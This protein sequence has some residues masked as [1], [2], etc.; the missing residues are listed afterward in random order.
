[1]KA[2]TELEWTL[3]FRLKKLE[4]LD[5]MT[6]FDLIWSILLCS[7]DCLTFDLKLLFPA[8]FEN[9]D[10]LLVR[11]FLTSIEFL[12][13]LRFSLISFNFPIIFLF[14]CLALV[15]IFCVCFLETGSCLDTCLLA[16]YVC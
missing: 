1:L 15:I 7:A 2:T 10:I 9:L 16:F 5:Y 12:N 6:R 14:F 4:A 8:N 13:S 3:L 11:S